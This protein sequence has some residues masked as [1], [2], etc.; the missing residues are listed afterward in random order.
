MLPNWHTF[1][2]AVIQ[3][4]IITCMIYQMFIW[5]FWRR[6]IHAS[7]HPC[8]EW[9]HF[10][11]HLGSGFTWL[12][13]FSLFVI[14]GSMRWRSSPSY[15]GIKIRL[16]CFSF[17]VNASNWMCILLHNM[18]CFMYWP[19][20]FIWLCMAST[21][22]YIWLTKMDVL[23]QKMCTHIMAAHKCVSTCSE[24]YAPH[25]LKINCASSRFSVC[26]VIEGSN[27]SLVHTFAPY[28]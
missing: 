6:I 3:L 28:S 15:L 12:V 5:F 20:K 25:V 18:F 27:V 10:W 19:W 21:F 16:V 11:G 7:Y 8:S 22:L 26:F 9:L 1:G 24:N 4:S 13:G 2:S 14:D 17:C 23:D